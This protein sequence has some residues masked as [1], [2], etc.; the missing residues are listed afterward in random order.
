MGL[1]G[2]RIPTLIGVNANEREAKQ[3]VVANVGLEEWFFEGEKEPA[4][5]KGKG[6]LFVAFE[7]VVG[8]VSI[9][10][11]S[12]LSSSLNNCENG[13]WKIEWLTGV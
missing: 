8:A 3:V 12:C 5:G 4:V 13:I 2:L 11:L 7:K 9:H 6:D 10:S 1:M